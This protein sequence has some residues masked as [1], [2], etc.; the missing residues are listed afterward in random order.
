MIIFFIGN[1]DD[2]GDGLFDEIN[3]KEIGISFM[4]LLINFINHGFISIIILL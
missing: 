3:F 4:D 2:V 1:L